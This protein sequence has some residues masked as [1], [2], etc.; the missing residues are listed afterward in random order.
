[1]FRDFLLLFFILYY[2]HSIC[3]TEE[4]QIAA[5]EN[6]TTNTERKNFFIGFPAAFYTP[7]TKWGFG[8]GGIYN[9]YLN[10][11]DS[12][13]PSSQIQLAASYTQR[14]QV[15]VYLPFNIYLNEW[16]NVIEGEFGYYDYIYPFYGLGDD[17][18]KN[19]FENYN[20]RYFRFQIDGLKRI[21]KDVF[22]GFRYWIDT[23]DIYKIKTDGILDSTVILG[24]TGGIISGFGPVVRLDKRDNV[25]STTKGSYI[26]LLYQGFNKTIGSE[27]NFGR[28]RIDARKFWSLKKVTLAAQ[29]YGDIN[30]GD[31]PFF[32]KAR[33]G[34][35]KRLRGYLE[36]RF[37]DDVSVIPQI[38]VRRDIL[39]R[40]GGVGFFNTGSVM[41][42]LKNFTN[43]QWRYTYGAGLRYTLDKK[44]GIKIRVDYAFT[45]EGTNFYFTIGEAF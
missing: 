7:E 21:K 18:R 41:P 28:V 43:S 25:Y 30:W 17:S 9:F 14:K 42:S 45:P 1:M 31:V 24:E 23:P 37:I 13:S 12:I 11:N 40:V 39:R 38:E 44:K 6:D 19:D 29:L 20:S 36:G 10:K 2:S 8:A 32:Q 35:T 33:L 27:F 4:V 22:A 26:S 16:S 34:G 5:Q 15:L 3:Q